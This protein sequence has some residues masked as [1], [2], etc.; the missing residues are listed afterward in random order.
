MSIIALL[1][2]IAVLGFLVYLVTLIPMP[3]AFKVAIIG[4]AVIALVGWVLQSFGFLTGFPK[5]HP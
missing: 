3:Q 2:W 1:F 4:I 5:L